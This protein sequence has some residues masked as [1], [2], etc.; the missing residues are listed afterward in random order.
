MQFN[1]LQFTVGPLSQSPVHASALDDQP[2][3]HSLRSSQV[4]G[5]G[6]VYG[7][8]GSLGKTPPPPSPVEGHHSMVP[9][10]REL[11]RLDHSSSVGSVR[12]SLVV[13]SG[14]PVGSTSHHPGDRSESLHGC[15]QLGLGSPARVTLETGTGGH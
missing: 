5:H 13:I 2:R 14:S 1:T 12:D 11:V 8:T 10:N 6:G 7:H 3:H 15:A 4:A 9:E